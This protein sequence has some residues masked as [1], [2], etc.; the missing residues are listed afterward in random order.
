MPD[1]SGAVF[2][3]G[4]GDLRMQALPG[5]GAARQF[6]LSREARTACMQES[7]RRQSARQRL[8]ASVAI[9]ALLLPTSQMLA[10]AGTPG[11]TQPGDTAGKGK[12]PPPQPSISQ[13]TEGLPPEPPPNY[14]QPLFMRPT[15]RDFGRAATSQIPSR[16]IPRPPRHRRASPTRRGL[17]T[18]SRTAKSISA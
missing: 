10:Q 5:A 16:R 17:R 11:Q 3:L 9:A 4:D 12:T 1:C 15:D 6:Q 2:S 7:S 13:T 14:T 18:W 8:F